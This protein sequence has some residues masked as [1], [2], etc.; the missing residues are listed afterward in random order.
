MD[1]KDI[2]EQKSNVKG[3]IY[4]A[5]MNIRGNWASRP[6]NVIVVN[7]TSAQS[8]TSPNRR[9]FSPMTPVDGTYKGFWNFEHYWQSGKKIEGIDHKINRRW[10]F[11]QTTPHRRY[12]NS[13]GKHVEYADWGNGPLQ[14]IESRKKVYVPEYYELIHDRPMVK[15][16]IDKINSGQ[17]VIVY[18]FDGPRDDD[19]YPICLEITKELLIEKI[20]DEQYPF[21]HVY[22][23]AGL[24]AGIHYSEY[25]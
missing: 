5:S 2:E 4:I 11:Q 25:V 14:Y 19:G 9:D 17:D 16:W 1:E 20:N 12:P 3:K 15:H 10:W 22:I 7:V 8:K 18:D 13:K 23:V 24:F 6:P 21:G